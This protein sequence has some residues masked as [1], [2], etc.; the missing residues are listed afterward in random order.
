MA[1]KIRSISKSFGNGDYSIVRT[2]V[3]K[4]PKCFFRKDENDLNL[5]PNLTK[6]QYPIL[7]EIPLLC[8]G[9]GRNVIPANLFLRFKAK[10]HSDYKTLKD[11]AQALLAFYRFM[12]INRLTIYDVNS[13]KENGVVYKFRDF[14]LANLKRDTGEGNVGFYSRSTAKSYILKVVEYY[15]FLNASKIIEISESFVPFEYKSITVSRRKLKQNKVD[16]RKLGHLEKEMNSIIVLTTGLTKKF[17]YEQSTDPHKKLKPMSD[18]D[19]QLFLDRLDDDF[20]NPKDLMLKLS[21]RTGLRLEELITFPLSEVQEPKA[22][23]VKC[24]ISEIRNGC[25]TKFNKERTIEV[26]FEL[27]NELNQYR[28]ST[29]RAN[30]INKSWLN[31]NCLF[32]KS[33]GYPF[34]PNTLEKHFEAIRNLIMKTHPTWYY[35]VHDLRSTFA[36]HW[37]CN[38][39][40]ETGLPFDTLLEDLK[41]IMGHENPSMTE[42]YTK[43]MNVRDNWFK[44]ARMQNARANKFSN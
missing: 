43:F 5:Q 28:L 44:F 3:D 35:R 14:L 38:R 42:K 31:H 1:K 17:G 37:L 22:E 4:Y 21:I 24:T 13:D 20:N 10:P 9:R 8:D 34:S 30:A 26:P 6:S 2:T 36:T 27:M 25:K 29:V 18:I 7:I 11:Y 23:F 15:N 33:D 16:S 32:V 39:H 12:L 19:M 40:L 41:E